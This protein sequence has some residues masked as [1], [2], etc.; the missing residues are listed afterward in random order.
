MK[1][2]W[3]GEPENEAHEM[4]SPKAKWVPPSVHFLALFIYLFKSFYSQA[5]RTLQNTP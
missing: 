4:K 1:H 2:C 3:A 5:T